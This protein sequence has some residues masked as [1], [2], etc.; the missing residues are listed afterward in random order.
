MDE[1]CMEIIDLLE[2]SQSNVNRE[3]SIFHGWI[4]TQERN[5]ISVNGDP[6]FLVRLVRKYGSL[7]W[8]YPVNQYS[9]RIAHPNIMNFNNHRGDN[10]YNIFAN[11][12]VYDRKF[13]L[14]N[15]PYLYDVLVTN[16]DLF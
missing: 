15:Q 13:S 8:I 7:K 9:L 11:M 16:N 10:K 4:Y 5:N 2:T 1:F 14:E 3:V 12:E 6:I